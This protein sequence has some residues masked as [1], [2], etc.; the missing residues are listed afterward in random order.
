MKHPVSYSEYHFS[1]IVNASTSHPAG[2]V[3]AGEI[4]QML[5][6]AAHRVAQ[7][8]SGTEVT[9]VR[10]DEMVFLTPIHVGNVISCHA[11]LTYV[12]NTSMEVE[13]NLYLDALHGNKPA[14]SAYFVMVA[15]NADQQPTPVPALDLISELERARFEAGRQRREKHLNSP[16]E[17]TAY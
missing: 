9:A 5:Y 12:G 8:H 15:L 2:R 11:K 14:L 10:I 4:M 6:N 13:V 17:E 1:K 3:Y 16:K 7:H